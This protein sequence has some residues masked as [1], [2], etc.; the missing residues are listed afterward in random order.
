MRIF[1][2]KANVAVSCSFCGKTHEEVA[3]LVAGPDGIYI[4]DACVTICSDLLARDLGLTS[5]LKVGDSLYNLDQLVSFEEVAVPPPRDAGWDAPPGRELVLQFSRG[6]PVRVP[7]SERER[8]EKA[9]RR[10][11][12]AI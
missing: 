10:S 7:V 11:K 9:L 1:P 6:E 3:K 2:K 8:I 4:C 5:L 12:R